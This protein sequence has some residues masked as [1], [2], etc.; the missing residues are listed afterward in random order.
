MT[1]YGPL[2]DCRTPNSPH[3]LLQFPEWE[4]VH[5][6]FPSLVTRCP[7]ALGLAAGPHDN[8]ASLAPGSLLSFQ[9][10]KEVPSLWQSWVGDGALSPG[11][12]AA[13]PVL[14]MA[15]WVTLMRECSSDSHSK[16]SLIIVGLNQ[17]LRLSEGGVDWNHADFSV[18]LPV[19][20]HFSSPVPY[21]TITLPWRENTNSPGT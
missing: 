8:T 1:L 14:W 9:G 15:Q 7:L 4:P 20:P 5:A 11:P 19:F 12:P 6:R 21:K 3:Y 2:H 10:S 13:L 16:I 17:C 18:S